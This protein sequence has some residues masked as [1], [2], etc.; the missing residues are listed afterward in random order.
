MRVQSG[1]ANRLEGHAIFDA[2]SISLTLSVDKDEGI[3]VAQEMS[4]RP[5]YEG[6]VG[7]VR[8]P[9]LRKECLHLE[10]VHARIDAIE[11][12]CEQSALRS[13]SYA[14]LLCPVV[15][16]HPLEEPRVRLIMASDLEVDK[17]ASPHECRAML[18]PFLTCTRRDTK[19]RKS[20]SLRN[21]KHSI[22]PGIAV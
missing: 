12:F 6:K 15:G 13:G 11:D 10:V 19:R 3:P 20:K 7:S 1:K 21:C 9:I 2:D 17:H 22:A 8:G 14:G 5:G 16:R 18:E 4:T